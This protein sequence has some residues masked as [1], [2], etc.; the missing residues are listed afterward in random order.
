MYFK[1]QKMIFFMYDLPAIIIFIIALA[2]PRQNQVIYKLKLNAK[3]GFSF[4]IQ[5]LVGN[6]FQFVVEFLVEP[7]QSEVK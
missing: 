2:L 6:S 4:I 7:V 3:L 5:I 1:I